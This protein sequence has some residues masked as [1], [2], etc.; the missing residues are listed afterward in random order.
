MRVCGGGALGRVVVALERGQQR[1]TLACGA[2]QHGVDEAMPASVAGVLGELHRVVDDGPVRRASQVEQ[3]VEPEPQRGEQR[4]V[5]ARDGP[6]CECRDQIVERPA[7]LHGAV[8]EP[9]RQRA[10]ARVETG[11]V[12][13]CTQRE[14]G[15]GAAL[16]DPPH[17]DIRAGPR[18]RRSTHARGGPWPRR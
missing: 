6:P 4:R 16:E 15:V 3:L 5:N 9:H 10:V 18:G 12:G 14:V 1:G 13:L 2:A 11:G 8:G 17:H 7:S